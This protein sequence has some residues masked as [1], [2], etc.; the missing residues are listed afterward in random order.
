VVAEEVVMA[1]Q[2]QELQVPVVEEREDVTHVVQTLQQT[3]VVV[4]EVGEMLPAGK[5]VEPVVQA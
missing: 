3:L 2:L 1:H 4:L 5:Q